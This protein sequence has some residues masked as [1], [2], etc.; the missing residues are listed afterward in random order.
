MKDKEKTEIMLKYL[1]DREISYGKG[2]TNV[3]FPELRL[4]SGYCGVSQRRI[5]LFIISSNAGNQT[6]AYEI[7]AS[8]SDFKK[9]IQDDLKQR[10][11]RLYANEFFY[12]AP[13]GMIKREEVPLWAGLIEFDFDKYEETEERDKKYLFATVVDAPLH[14]K[15]PPSW[16]LI[17][18]MIRHVNKDIGK[19][20]I[21]EL[22]EEIRQLKYQEQ[23][24]RKLLSKIANGEEYHSWELTEYK[25]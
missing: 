8:R 9:D 20:T 10:G 23:R 5:D 13:K 15:Y 6:T 1:I 3:I 24:Q 4:G 19:A 21:A 22:K 7:K 14:P 11:A 16:G 25:K 2:R 17:C 12:V 18:S